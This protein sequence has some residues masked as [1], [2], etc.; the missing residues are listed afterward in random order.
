MI[1]LVLLPSPLLGA[2]TWAPVATELARRGHLVTLAAYDRQG[3]AWESEHL[4]PDAEWLGRLDEEV[5]LR[6]AGLLHRV[7]LRHGRTT[8][9]PA[10]W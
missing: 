6:A 4:G 7:S 2:A 5:H 8:T 3:L 10:S 9:E 1:R